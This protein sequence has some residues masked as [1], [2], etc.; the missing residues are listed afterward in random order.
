MRYK[1]FIDDERYPPTSYDGVI[2]IIARSSADAIECVSLQ[3]IPEYI[4][5][6]HDLGGEDTSMQFLK[7]LFEASD[8][9]NN[10][11]PQ[12]VPFSW[13]VHSMNPIGK[14]NIEAYLESW[15]RYVGSYDFADYDDQDHT[16]FA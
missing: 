15:N 2:W 14:K 10:S 9:A 11:Q 5:F 3:G 1:L 6:D 12:M 7:W 16:S 13:Y 8:F 4:S